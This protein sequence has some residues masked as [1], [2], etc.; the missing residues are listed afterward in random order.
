[1]DYSPEW[2]RITTGLCRATAKKALVELEEK[3]YLVKKDDK[4]FDFFDRQQDINNKS[5]QDEDMKE[6]LETVRRSLFD[7]R[8]D[9]YDDY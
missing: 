6:I 1:M 5:I 3:N 8:H 9:Y 4:H 2:F 7:R